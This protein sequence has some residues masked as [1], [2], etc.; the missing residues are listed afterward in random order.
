MQLFTRP[1]VKPF[2]VRLI[3]MV[4]VLSLILPAAALPPAEAAGTVYVNVNY[5][6]SGNTKNTK[7]YN[8]STYSGSAGGGWGIY[9]S[10]LETDYV[11]IA[12]APQR[13][14][15]SLKIVSN[16][17]NVNTG[18]NNLGGTATGNTGI[19]GK[20]VLEASVYMNST[21]HRREIQFRSLNAPSPATLTT[22]IAALTFNAAGEVRGAGNQLL[23]RYEK[24]S[25]YKLKMFVDSTARTVSYFMNDQ[26]LGEASLPSGWLNIRHI[27]LNQ[28][29]Q[30]GQQGEWLVDDLKLA[31]YVP[32][33][34]ISTSVG[35]LELAESTSANIAVEVLP[36]NASDQRLLWTTADPSVATVT[37][38]TVHALSEG[39]TTVMVSTYEGDYSLAVPL[40]VTKP[41]LPQGISLPNEV[42]LTVTGQQTLKPGFQPANTTNQAV[43]WSS[44]DPA[45]ATVDASG[46]ITGRSVGS[47]EI[48][49]V[50]QADPAVSAAV[51]VVVTPYIPVTAVTITYSP[52][53]LSKY[54]SLQLIADIE[55]ADATDSQLTWVSNRPDIVRV[56]ADGT[57]QGI[58]VGTA[59]V[60][61]SAV[62]GVADSV[63]LVVVAAQPDNPQEYDE[64]RL[65]WKETLTGKDSLDVNDPA[66]QAILQANAAAA[67]GY[68]E[69]MQLIPGGTTLWTD[70]PASTSDSAFV[71]SHY[72]RLKTMALAYQTQGTPLYHNSGL[73][74]DLLQA[75][76][77]MLDELYT[78][79]G[80]EFGNWW[81]WDI[82]VPNRLADILILMYD[83]LTPEQILQNTASI[84]HYIGDITAPSFTQTGANRSDI[85]LIQIRMGLVEHSYD[86]LIQAR[87]G[88]SELFQYT[89]A[90][91]G[92]YEDGS[93]VQHSTIAYTG[94]YGEVLI[95]GMGNLLFLLNGSTWEPV[96]P[97]VNNVYRWINEGFAPILYKGQA[98]DMTRGRAIVRPAADAY[99]SGRNILAG[100]ARIA[101][102]SPPELS[103]KLKG[104]VKYHAGYQLSQ[105][106]SYYQFP[107]DLA[108]T[109]RQWVDDPAI[110]PAADIQAHYELNGM[111]RSVHRG[112]DFLFGVSK[113]SKRIA[114]YELTNGENPKGWYTGDGMTY[115]YNRDLSQ[116]TGSFWATVNWSR[117]P[118]T[119]VVSRPRNAGDYQYGDG[120]TAPLNSWA[121]GTTLDTFGATG[122]NLIQNGTQMQARKSWFAFD[123]EIVALGAGITST[124]N[125]P[126]ETVIEQRKLKEDNSNSFVLDGDTLNGNI[127]G[128]EI[129][130]PSWAYLEGNAADSNIGYVFPDNSSI[131]LTRQVQEGRWSDIN[132]S[133]PPSSTTPTGLLQNYFLTMWMD[134]GSNPVDSRYEYMIL[135]NASRQATEAYADSPD[136]TILA[137]SPAVQAVRENTLNVTGYNFWT[138]ALTSA[139]GVTSNKPASVL[140]RNNA[141]AGTTKLAVSDPTLENQGVI[142]LELEAEAAGILSKDDRIEV[143]QLSPKVKLKIHTAG[144]LGRTMLI[145]LQT[146]SANK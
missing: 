97:G 141:D 116:Y 17:K 67:Q 68:W 77:W 111:A 76:D 32:L 39:S 55:P 22:N 11:T 75:M 57:L 66:V 137:N 31:D 9:N 79:S 34:G 132:L 4:T 35:T 83:E 12:N 43:T 105:G 41:V 16:T 136:V 100:I 36:Q 70:L 33:T 90:G 21:T 7:L 130:N 20:L 40:T 42:N 139:G 48:T 13:E 63:T 81:N 140:I 62:N 73:K 49:A 37:Y 50:S 103:L 123:N 122:M 99:Y 133:N 51:T 29:F 126:V 114:T 128:Q 87:D 72:T 85:M 107:L 64:I 94:S 47:A 6:E 58:S 53:Q 25:W 19:A 1:F 3:L 10:A 5:D 89:A 112:E 104:L 52:P 101:Q 86:R 102:T 54:D 23:A 113:S 134:H 60:S 108:D 131:K 119:T 14:D 65:R 78:D 82:G 127:P 142:E 2:L 84:D 59:T 109:I 96:V 144:T 26:Y 120:E 61:A 56:A 30:S 93:Y 88:M 125:L 18:R 74:D 115:L 118:G 27:Y 8:G 110:V 24:N 71:N 98:I 69:S 80:S 138:D 95:Q 145:T 46:E 38:G 92:F 146:A 91:D 129:E 117:L 135:P 106:A 121:G 45:V 124:D 28:Y 44:A 15:Y 143:T